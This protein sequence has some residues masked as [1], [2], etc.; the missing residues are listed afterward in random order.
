M[1]LVAEPAEAF[2]QLRPRLLALLEMHR[3][4]DSEELRRRIAQTL[5]RVFLATACHVA[6]DMLDNGW[7]PLRPGGEAKP[8]VVVRL[9]GGTDA[10]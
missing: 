9:V 10:A 1:T 2:D 5:E 8:G 6:Q 3:A 7:R 4:A